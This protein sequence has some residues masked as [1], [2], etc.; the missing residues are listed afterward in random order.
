MILE[1]NDAQ[2]HKN[3]QNDL[4]DAFYPSNNSD[5][6]F[7]HTLT[8]IDI[9]TLKGDFTHI[10][11][12]KL[13]LEAG[14]K[15]SEVTTHNDFS[16]V[17][18]NNGILKADSGQNNN[19][20]YHE[21]VNAVYF[22][23]N[24][25]M[26]RWGL[27]VGARLEQ[28]HV[29]GTSTD[30]Y[31]KQTI[32]PDSNYVKLLPAI[33]LT[34][35]PSD[36]D[37]VRLSLNERL[38]RPNYSDLQPFSYQIDP[39]DEQIGNPELRVQRTYNAELAYTYN[40]RV[41]LTADYTHTVDF[42]TPVTYLVNNIYYQTVQNTGT[43]DNWNFNLNYPIKVT[44]WW[45]ML[46]KAS[47]FEN[48]FAGQL[49]EG[50]LDVAKWSYYLSTSQRFN[51]PGNVLLQ[52]SARYNSPLQTLIYYSED[53]SSVGIS[54]SKK[55][56]KGQGSIRLGFRD[57]FKGQHNDVIV[58]FEDLHYIQRNTW[59]SQRAFIEFN[60]QFGK[61][62]IKQHEDRNSANSEEKDRSGG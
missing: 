16:A 19:Y 59:E 27:Q 43:T 51:I 9:L 20:N 7:Y 32:K 28:S 47:V 58:N 45:N 44:K 12:S 29:K 26:G 34:Y 56:L 1:L 53:N 8:N 30:G 3:D 36:K 11:K 39:T 60:W 23:L 24:K 49:Y 50:F 41:T 37:N 2:F 4:T 42:F 31:G 52:L 21:D 18:S 48:R 55:V 15:L 5:N 22:N 17:T 33:Y 6:N 46:T 57:L 40:D 54:L 13:K 35:Q 10:W 38:K 14:F 25:N 61:S 62:K